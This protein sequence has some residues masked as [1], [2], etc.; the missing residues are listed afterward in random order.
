MGKYTINSQTTMD[1]LTPTPKRGQRQTRLTAYTSPITHPNDYPS[2]IY[3]TSAPPHRPPRFG[4]LDSFGD[5][6]REQRPGS[7]Q[8]HSSSTSPLRP[9][10]PESGQLDEVQQGYAYSA[11]SAP[12]LQSS[13]NPNREYHSRS[14][15]Y[16]STHA[17]TD[18]RLD[19]LLS[20]PGSPVPNFSRPFYTKP[21]WESW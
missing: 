10:R 3:A 19:Y 6:S 17:E 21:T 14:N 20:P 11:Q 5:T 2:T 13:F 4:G 16:K 18:P 7:G 1:T 15:S 9:H 8:S 12:P